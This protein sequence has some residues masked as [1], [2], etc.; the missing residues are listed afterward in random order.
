M[1]SRGRSLYRGETAE[2]ANLGAGSP[3]TMGV[4]QGGTS[5][6][7]EGLLSDVRLYGRALSHPEIAAL[8]RCS[9]PQ[10]RNRGA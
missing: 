10:P 3:W 9:L 4:D 6:P 2:A 8:Y 5:P 7:F 1:A